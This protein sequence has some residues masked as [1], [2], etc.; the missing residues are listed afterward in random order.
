[1]NN[2]E[3][4][5]VER[6]ENIREKQETQVP[7]HFELNQ[8]LQHYNE[9]Y[10]TIEDQFLVVDDLL[11]KGNKEACDTI[12]RSQIVLAEGLLDFYIHEL[13]KYCLFQMFLEQRTK[14][15]KYQ[16]IMIPMEKVEVGLRTSKSKNWFYEFLNGKFS[17]EVYLSLESMR[18][19]LNLIGIG[20]SEVIEKAFS[21]ESN[22]IDF[23]KNRIKELFERRNAIAHQNDRSHL[24]A[25]IAPITK[26]Y[27]KD[28]IDTIDDLILSVHIIAL[29]R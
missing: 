27:V 12:W 10:D 7:L 24:S 5:L 14:T 29:S 6:I 16:K 8:I 15:D 20:F 9:T 19:Q 2:R 17:R 11:S 22:P 13:S 26:E 3:L 23:G 4:F 18:D 25:A 21:K 28:Y 1:M